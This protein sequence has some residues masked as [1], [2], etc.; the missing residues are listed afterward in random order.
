MHTVSRLLACGASTLFGLAIV[1]ASAAYAQSSECGCVVAAGTAGVVQ[2][3]SG[4]V[5]VSQASGS[6]PAQSSMPLQAGSSVLVGP[7]SA[8]VVSFGGNCTL[9]LPANSVFEVRPQGD[10]LCL[11][12]NE[13][14]PGQAVETTAGGGASDLLV[15]GVIAGGLG[16][17]AIAIAASDSDN[18]VSK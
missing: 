4:N 9:R 7:Q 18:S 5:F 6:V 11:A 10:Q 13:Q 8:S 12:V 16:L 17:G 3:A 15:P 2:S 14:A 1:G